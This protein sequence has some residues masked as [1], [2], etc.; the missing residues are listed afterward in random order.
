MSSD[1][2]STD[3]VISDEVTVV[4]ALR[5]YAY[6]K[7]INCFTFYAMLFNLQQS[8]PEQINLLD[9]DFDPQSCVESFKAK[10]SKLEYVPARA[11]LL[12]T[13]GEDLYQLAEVMITG[14]ID[15]ATPVPDIDPALL[16]ADSGDDILD[17]AINNIDPTLMFVDPV[18]DFRLRNTGFFSALGPSNVVNCFCPSSAA[19]YKNGTNKT[20]WGDKNW[21]MVVCKKKPKEKSRCSFFLPGSLV[22]RE[23]PHG[24]K[25][26]SEGRQKTIS[27]LGAYQF[28]VMHINKIAGNKGR[29]IFMKLSCSCQS[30][31]ENPTKPVNILMDI[32]TKVIKNRDVSCQVLK[33][34]CE[35]CAKLYPFCHMPVHATSLDQIVIAPSISEFVGLLIVE[36]KKNPATIAMLL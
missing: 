17:E 25:R 36:I 31:S 6:S 23:I 4:D 26:D 18:K 8:N 12:A 9:L 15:Y 33:Y 2:I 5:H 13:L 3:K 32:E 19:A 24:S 29:Q 1:D 14:G 27:I 11:K 7:F 35:D 21:S 20:A 22:R 34:K 16:L 30:L 28:V 10:F